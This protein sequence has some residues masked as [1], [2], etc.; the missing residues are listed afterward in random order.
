[1]A[2]EKQSRSN[3]INATLSTGPKTDEGKM[4]ASKNA[5]KHG[6]LSNILNE[7]DTSS[8]DEIE[9]ALRLE[10]RIESMSD[11]IIFNQILTTIIKLNRCNR[12]ESEYFQEA[13]Y[14]RTELFD[15]SFTKDE[16]QPAKIRPEQLAVIGLIWEKYEPRLVSRLLKLINYF[17]FKNNLGSFRQND[18]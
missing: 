7:F 13:L 1:M 4:T 9:S 2:T 12:I 14:P 15:V 5:T 6:I 8:I 3:K 10:F 16:G 18:V 17:Q 11:E